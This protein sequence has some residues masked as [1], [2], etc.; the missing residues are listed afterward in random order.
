MDKVLEYAILYTS[1]SIRATKR[2]KNYSNFKK[3]TY[4]IVIETRLRNSFYIYICNM[5]VGGLKEATKGGSKY[6]K[7]R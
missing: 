3:T 7:T 4:R 1:V 5:I 6:Y 2:I